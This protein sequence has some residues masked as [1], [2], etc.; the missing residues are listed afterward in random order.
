MK[1]G[2]LSRNNRGME[3]DESLQQKHQLKR[4]KRE[5]DKE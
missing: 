3:I 4:S 5:R 2:S 1:Y